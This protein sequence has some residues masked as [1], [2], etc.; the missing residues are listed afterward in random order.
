MRCELESKRINDVFDELKKLCVEWYPNAVA[1]LLRTLVEMSLANYLDKS[2]QLT[3]LS[4]KVQRKER[5]PRDWHP[6]LKQ[7]MNYIIQDDPEMKLNPNAMKS[8]TKLVS[9]KE[10][11]F[12]VDTFNYFVHNPFYHPTEAHLRGLWSALEPVLRVTLVEPEPQK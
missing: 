7:M 3:A 9:E 6:T 11:M 10:S 8:L 4:K 1:M 5:K 2:G 12:A